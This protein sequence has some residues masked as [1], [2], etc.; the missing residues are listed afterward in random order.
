MLRANTSNGWCQIVVVESSVVAFP[1][2]DNLTSEKQMPFFCNLYYGKINGEADF[3]I[4]KNSGTITQIELI[5]SKCKLKIKLNGEIQR[6]EYPIPP[7][8]RVLIDIFHPKTEIE[9]K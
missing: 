6:G 3:P 7:I 4:F 1:N 5:I 2:P 9:I 8:F